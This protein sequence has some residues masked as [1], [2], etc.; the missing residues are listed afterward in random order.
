[1]GA[2]SMHDWKGGRRERK[3][4]EQRNGLYVIYY[5]TNKRKNKRG[6]G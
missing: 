4:K 3:E 5:K 1:V 2:D 6:K